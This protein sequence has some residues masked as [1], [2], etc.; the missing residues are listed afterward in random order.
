MTNQLKNESDKIGFTLLKKLG[1]N[2]QKIHESD[3]K[4]ADFIAD[5]KEVNIIVEAKLKTDSDNDIKSKKE[6]LEKNGSSII[7]NKE[8]YSNT[9]A[10]I[11]RESSKQSESSSKNN[12]HYF[13]INL[14]IS[15]GINAKTKA[16]VFQDTLY[17]CTSIIIGNQ[18]KK[19]YFFSYSEFIKNDSL[20]GSIISYFDY[21]E[22][23]KTIFCIN[24]YSKNYNELKKSKIL[25]LFKNSIID[26]IELEQK[27]L[28]YI[29]DKDIN[30]KLTD[31]EKSTPM[32]NPILNHIKNKYK[33]DDYIV[34]GNFSSPEITTIIK[35]T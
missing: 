24:P 34:C 28:I 25:E 22:S 2:V 15:K 33:I 26:P 27:G 32:Y 21:D 3:K 8:G 19:C 12:K 31:I 16:T 9:Y 17:G 30:R 29:A 1:F 35:D 7:D 20:D 11:I 6:Q 18:E 4:E 10:G 13:K 5:Y 23:I 14:L